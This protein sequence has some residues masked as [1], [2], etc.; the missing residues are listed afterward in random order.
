MSAQAI[1]DELATYGIRARKD[2]S[3]RKLRR[4][5]REARSLYHTAELQELRNELASYGIYPRQNCGI[6]KL[7]LKLKKA[8]QNGLPSRTTLGGVSTTQPMRREPQNVGLPSSMLS[9]VHRPILSQGP[10]HPP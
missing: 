10:R 9:G 6:K 2:S 8:Q 5:L 3:M 1:R 7:R 4:N